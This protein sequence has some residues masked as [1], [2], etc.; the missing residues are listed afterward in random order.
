[1]KILDQVVNNRYSIY[2]G[3]S[4]DITKEI[5]DNSIHYI[6]FSPPFSSLYTY[7]NSDRDM[8]NCKGDE[9]FYN[10]F[11]YLAK[12]LYRITMPGRL[13]SFHCMDLPLMKERDGV[14]G[15]K[16]FPAMVRQVFE[17]CGFIYHSRVTIFKNPV[18]EMQRTHALG[19]L[20]KQIRKDSAM[21]RQGLPDYIITMRKPGDNPEM[22]PHTHENFPVNVWQNYASPVWMDIRQSDTLQRKSA[23]AEEDEKHICFASGTL[24]LT[25]R[26][27]IPI[28]N[29]EPNN[30]EVLTNSGTWQKVVAKMKTAENAKVIKV[31]AIGVPNLISTPDHK[32]MA[33]RKDKNKNKNYLHQVNEEWVMAKDVENCYLKFIIPPEVDSSISET[34]WWIIGRYLADGHVDVRGHQFFLSIGDT[35]WD[36]FVNRAEKH[37]GCVAQHKGCKQV[38]LIEL[39]DDAKEILKKCG[40]KAHNKNVP[41]EGLCLNSKLSK[42]LCEGY[43]SGDGFN[44]PDGKITATSVSRALLLGI[45]IVYYKAYGRI[46]AIYS[47]RD[48]RQHEIEGRIVNA[49]KEWIFT[50]SPNYTFNV[51]DKEKDVIWK[52]VKSIKDYGTSDVWSIEVENDHSYIAEGCVVKNCPLQLSVIQRCIELWTNPND[53]VFD[54]FGGIGSTSYVALTLGRRTISSELKDS[55]FEQMKGNVEE[56]LKHPVMDCPV[57]QMEIDDFIENDYQVTDNKSGDENAMNESVAS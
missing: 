37:I 27:Y 15:L 13:L 52:K 43:L 19:L 42:C 22:I 45:Q 6:L 25:K 46:G 38:G 39:S 54:P 14:I 21:C 1:M 3:D 56:A 18:T 23:R 47:G 33:K 51:V 44:M 48:A 24:V 31:N 17:D 11:K 34:E 20:H 30:D 55:Y 40:D 49:K 35:K 12:E 4:V 5:P 28:E 9:E 26:G 2:H 10:H 8:G 32:L 53:I 50:V 29:I 41:Y 16:D 57:G 36:D 7:S